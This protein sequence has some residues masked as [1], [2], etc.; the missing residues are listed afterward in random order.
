M[1]DV[2]R[3]AVGADDSNVLLAKAEIGCEPFAPEQVAKTEENPPASFD[4]S[5]KTRVF[6]TKLQ[7]VEFELRGAPWTT[8]KIKVSSLFAQRRGSGASGGIG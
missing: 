8:R 3:Y 4:L 2:I 6:S 7:F 1:A 5:V